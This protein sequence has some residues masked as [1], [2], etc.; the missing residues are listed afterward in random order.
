MVQCVKKKMPLK[1]LLTCNI[2]FSKDFPTAS[3]GSLTEKLLWKLPSK[4]RLPPPPHRY[5]IVLLLCYTF[6]GILIYY[7]YYFKH[8]FYSF[9][10]LHLFRYDYLFIS[11]ENWRDGAFYCGDLSGKTVLVS[12][13]YVFLH[14]NSEPF[15]KKIGRFRLLFSAVPVGT[16][17]KRE[18]R[19]SK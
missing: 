1:I 10:Y 13:H 15:G 8:K 12:G 11:S 6:S 5:V 18:P 2:K 9:F 3:N 17:N 14:F 19:T 16:C 7:L 4:L